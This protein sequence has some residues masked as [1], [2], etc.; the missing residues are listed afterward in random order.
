MAVLTVLQGNK[1][2]E[3]PFESGSL[4]SDVLHANGFEVEHPCGGRGVCGRC[5]VEIEGEVSEMNASEQK[6]GAHLACQ[7]VLKGDATVTLP[8]SNALWQIETSGTT[9]VSLDGAMP[10]DYGAAVDIGTTTIAVKVYNLH[11]GECVGGSAMHNPQASVA[12]D[13]MGR[14]D[15]AL[16]GKLEFMSHQVRSA[17]ADLLKNACRDAKISTEKVT[18]LVITGNTTMLYLL[19]NRNPETL[20]HAPFEAD[21]LF[22]E[23]LNQDGKLVYLPTC[24]NAF[25]GGDITCA[26]LAADQYG[27]DETT[28]LMD[29]GT[30][31]EIALWKDGTLYVTSTAAGPAFEGVGIYCGCASINGAIDRAAVQDG[32]IAVHTIG[33]APAVGI[34]GS[35]VFDVVA[36]ALQVGLIDETGA[37]EDDD[38]PLDNGVCL[39]PKDVR[40]IQLAKAAIAAGLQT[41][42]EEAHVTPEQ[43]ST[44]YIAGGFGSHLNVES[45]VRIGLIPEELAK[46]AKILG[47]AALSGAARILLNSKDREQLVKIAA[48]SKHLNLGGNPK[49]NANY[50]DS[51]FF[52]EE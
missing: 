4:L 35:G 28:V 48:S 10:G 21:C 25:V 5:A 36:C 23:L 32:K 39:L 17:I 27:K 12:A 40:A 31:G 18:S 42:M 8:D 24:M 50:V 33:E 29:I 38:L 52:P 44:L 20:S 7:T 43:V 41:L 2:T 19:T 16:R 46:K 47:N 9:P 30:N 49:F 45:G 37:M 26:V 1:R 15:A 6:F 34:C 11:T 51:M 22:G 3:I 14:I 13:V